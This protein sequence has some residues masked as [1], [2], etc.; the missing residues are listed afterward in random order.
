MRVFQAI[1]Q[2]LVIHPADPGG[3]FPRRP[4]HGRNRQKPPRVCGI[5]R[6]L[7]NPRTSLIV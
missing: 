7:S 5:I 3:I 6:L 1:P 4:Q 2:G